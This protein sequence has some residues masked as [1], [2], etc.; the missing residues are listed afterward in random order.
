MNKTG[1]MMA[2]SDEQGHPAAA[3]TAAE[4][5]K[6]PHDHHPHLASPTRACSEFSNHGSISAMECMNKTDVMVAKREGPGHPGP[7]RTANTRAAEPRKLLHDHHPHLA[8]PARAC[9]EFSNHGSISAM[10]CMNKTGVMMDTRDGPRTSR[11]TH[12]TQTPTARPRK[13]LSHHTHP[14]LAPPS[15]RV[16]SE[17]PKT[18]SISA[19][20]CTNSH[21][22]PTPTR[23]TARTWGGQHQ[24]VAGATRFSPP[25]SPS[26]HPQGYDRARHRPGESAFH[27]TMD[28]HQHAGKP[29][30]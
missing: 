26:H 8:P 14:H 24:P 21:M 1:D 7:A 19:M 25:R 16:C 20:A 9:S 28:T 12:M 6:L 22:R 23:G 17:F 10:A 5:R 18:G 11:P 4:P 27:G 15:R 3:R 30:T 2:T 29:G 13:P